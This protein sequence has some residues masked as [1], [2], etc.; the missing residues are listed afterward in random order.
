M[1]EES[2]EDIRQRNRKEAEIL[3]SNLGE[4]G[5][6]SN[7]ILSDMNLLKEL[8]QL[9]ESMEWFSVRMLNFTRDFRQEPINTPQIVTGTV[10]TPPPVSPGT[11]Q[12][13][14]SLAQEF[15]ELAN[16]CLLLLHLEV[17][18]QCFHYLLVQSDYNKETHEPDPKVLELSRVL[19]NVDEAMTSSLHPRKCKYIF[20][21]L[22]HLIAKILISSCQY[23]KVIDE[24][25]IQR[26]CRNVFA[27]QQTLT[28]IT[29]TREIALDHAR[30][31]FELFFLT[32]DVS[33]LFSL[34]S[35]FTLFLI[36]IHSKICFS[37]VI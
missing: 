8:A 7:E 3:A 23:M 4:G 24:V 29:M 36:G 16:T 10:D 2:P 19:A 12:Q 14:T 22:G 33:F 20:E 32:P 9:Q 5:V 21:G 25:G 15:D 17:R 26:M 37:I 11:L 31:Y 6:S 35:A 13:L 30:H 34:L 28:N 18:V 27:L 1:D